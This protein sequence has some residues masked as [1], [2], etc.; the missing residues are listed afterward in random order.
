[1]YDCAGSAG[2]GTIP[3]DVFEVIVLNDYVIEARTTMNTLLSEAKINCVITI[4]AKGNGTHTIKSYLIVS[5]SSICNITPPLREVACSA[6]TV[7]VGQ[8]YERAFRFGCVKSE[9]LVWAIA[10]IGN[11]IT[12]P[13][14]DYVTAITAV[15]YIVVSLAQQ[16]ILIQTA[17]Q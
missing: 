7:T 14:E 4:T 3:N 1:M 9:N 15:D 17:I 6:R 12:C 10:A 13:A 11:I 2:F 8:E 16:T 5:I